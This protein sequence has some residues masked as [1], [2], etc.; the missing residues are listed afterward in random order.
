MNNLFQ[1][2]KRLEAEGYE[3]VKKEMSKTR[4][5][6]RIKDLQACGFSKVFLQNLKSDAK[7]NVVPFIK[8]L[9]INFDQQVPSD[10]IEPIS[11]FNQ[12]ELRIA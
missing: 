3:A 10:F 9:E 2:Y 6:D 5:C 11:T 4:F 7:N 1:F 8:Y 12:R